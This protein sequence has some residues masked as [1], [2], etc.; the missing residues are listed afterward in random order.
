MPKRGGPR[1]YR[2]PI[3]RYVDAAGN[4]VKKGARGA[5][6][7]RTESESYYAD[8]WRDGKRER[9]PLGATNEGDAWVAIRAEQQRR[10]EERR[11]AARAPEFRPTGLSEHITAWQQSMRD[12]GAVKSHV[13][14]FES[15]IR[16]LSDLAGWK[17]LEHI[18]ADSCLAALSRLRTEKGR[19]AQTRNHYLSAIKQF[20]RWC[21]TTSRFATHPL[22]G[23]RPVSVEGQMRHERRIPTDDEVVL[24]FDHLER[25][26]A[27]VR[28]GMT[29]R[30][31]ALAYKVMMATGFRAG[32]LRSLER[33]G[34]DLEAGTITLRAGY[35]KRRRTDTQHIPDWLVRELRAWLRTGGTPL[36]EKFP[37]QRPGRYTLE[38]DLEDAGISRIVKGPDGPLFFDMHSL[39]HYYCT[40]IASQPGMDPKTL[41]T[42]TRHS[43]VELAL[44]KY[45]KKQLERIKAAVQAIPEPTGKKKRK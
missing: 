25:P 42:L 18:T 3:T 11:G 2:V 27:P 1:P 14:L 40:Q 39:R 21:W 7:V 24:L 28:E 10:V 6:R 30:H 20:C 4:R 26:T 12:A 22:V 9:I 34:I 37:K 15:R 31:R 5:T 16:Y 43:S 41:V 33:D 17:K 35:S 38:P 19:S 32:E 29:G 13:D 23:L 8:F 36:F 44:K 45:A